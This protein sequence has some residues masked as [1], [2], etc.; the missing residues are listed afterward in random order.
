MFNRR[1]L[2][3]YNLVKGDGLKGRAFEEIV[4]RGVERGQFP[5]AIGHEEAWIANR[6]RT[7]RT[8]D[9][10]VE[11][12]LSDGRWFRIV[13]RSTADGG[14]VG[15]RT[16]ITTLKNAIAELQRSEDE[17]ISLREQF[18]HAQK[19]RAL[20][21]L[22][23]GVA[24]DFNNLLSIIIG[25]ADLLSN[26]LSENPQLRNSAEA[27]VR[28]GE[29]GANLV[30]QI[31]L[32]ARRDQIVLSPLRLDQAIDE[33]F[34]LLRSTLP[35]SVNLRRRIAPNITA[36]GNRTWI[37]QI[38]VNLCVNA[39]HAIGNNPGEIDIALEPV[40]IQSSDPNWA[41]LLR[42]RPRNIAGPPTIASDGVTLVAHHGTLDPGPHCR[43]SV[44]DTGAGMDQAVLQRIFEPFFTTREV[45]AG[46]GLGL[47]AVSGIV[48]EM[49]GALLVRSAPGLGATFEV[50]LPTIASLPASDRPPGTSSWASPIRPAPC[51]ISGPRRSPGTWR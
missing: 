22:A 9:G 43:I 25:H 27:I 16:D 51:G 29:R 4:R 21:A 1:Y 7:H 49:N 2:D 13:E 12:K 8:F 26:G 24:H 45:G 42:G 46:T 32:Y 10:V 40:N 15:V 41:R 23:G 38:L 34:D 44:R 18:F 50:Y 6:V 37:H 20:G 30:K 39:N 19:M 3:I 17:R 33:A 48:A 5:E 31:L 35:S 11:Q 47:A 28:S 36:N 14:R